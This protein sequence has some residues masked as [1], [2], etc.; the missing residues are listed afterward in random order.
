MNF[1]RSI[2]S[3]NKLRK[4]RE[5][6]NGGFKKRTKER[7]DRIK[8]KLE[9]MDDNFKYI[10]IEAQNLHFYCI[11]QESILSCMMGD[12]SSSKVLRMPSNLF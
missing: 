11:V 5:I 9:A 4:R 7:L 8:I 6:K 10:K 1:I 3:K 2:F 12:C